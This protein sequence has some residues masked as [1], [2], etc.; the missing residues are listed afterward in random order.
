MLTVKSKGL[1]VI[2]NMMCYVDVLVDVCLRMT[3]ITVNI[4]WCCIFQ[5]QR[6]IN[7]LQRNMQLGWLLQ[8]FEGD[9]LVSGR[10]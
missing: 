9:L 8:T 6:M 4:R 10:E 2:H 7:R 5:I 1:Y 3:C